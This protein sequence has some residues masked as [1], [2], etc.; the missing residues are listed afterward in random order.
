ME[1]VLVFSLTYLNARLLDFFKFT[2]NSIWFCYP[3]VLKV[4]IMQYLCTILG[5]RNIQCRE[6]LVDGLHKSD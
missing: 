6:L 3:S 5:L 4:T 1:P 2:K